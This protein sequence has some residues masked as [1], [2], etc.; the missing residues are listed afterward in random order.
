MTADFLERNEDHQE[1]E[2]EFSEEG[3]LS[4]DVL[5]RFSEVT[6][7][8]ILSKH[9]DLAFLGLRILKMCHDRGIDLK[10]QDA[11]F[12]KKVINILTR[13]SAMNSDLIQVIFCLLDSSLFQFIPCFSFVDFRIVFHVLKEYLYIS[14]E[15]TAPILFLKHLITAKVLKTEVY[16]MIG[17]LFTVFYETQNETFEK[18][19]SETILAFIMNFPIDDL[20]LVKY[21]TDLIQ[22]IDLEG[23]FKRTSIVQ[24]LFS[25]FEKYGVQFCKEFVG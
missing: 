7:K 24:F 17:D 8:F 23:E 6:L 11:L 14:D 18:E 21:A 19:S 25:L 20:L 15:V 10:I 4:G 3:R 2:G 12:F 22:H 1:T 5:A 9:D 16:D 13:T